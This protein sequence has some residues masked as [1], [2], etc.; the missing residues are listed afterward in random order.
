MNITACVIAGLLLPSHIAVAQASNVFRVLA[1]SRTWTMQKEMQAAGDAGFRYAA[2]MGGE[3]AV[4]G[5]EVVVILERNPV[6]PTERY[7]YRLL[8][9]PNVA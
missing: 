2:V 1:T 4:G 3:T 6:A 7:Q 8:A 5:K 9:T